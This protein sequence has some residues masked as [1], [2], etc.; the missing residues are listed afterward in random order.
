MEFRFTNS[1]LGCDEQT[2]WAA[3][4]AAGKPN[5]LN[6]A[7]T[8]AKHRFFVIGEERLWAGLPYFSEANSEL[9]PRVRPEVFLQGAKGMTANTPPEADAMGGT[10]HQGG[11]DAFRRRLAAVPK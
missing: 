1:M 7:L 3:A 5:L 9:L 2:R 11:V 4:W 6:V 10:T 8:R